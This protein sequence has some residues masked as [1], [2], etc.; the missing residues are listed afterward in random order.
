MLHLLEI[1]R[2]QV[3]ILAG[4]FKAGVSECFLQVEYRPAMPKIIHCEGV[5]Q[6]VKASLHRGES[7]TLTQFFEVP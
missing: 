3:G 7:E 6:C 2:Q 1:I 5:S 4:H